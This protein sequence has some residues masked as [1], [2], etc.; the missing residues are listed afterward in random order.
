MYI[1]FLRLTVRVLF[2]S[3]SFNATVGDSSQT[4]E[5]EKINCTVMNESNRV[6]TLDVCY[7]HTRRKLACMCVCVCGSGTLV[8]E[9]VAAHSRITFYATYDIVSECAFTVY[10]TVYSECACYRVRFVWPNFY[11]Y[12]N[13]S[14][15]TVSTHF[16]HIR[17][18]Q[19]F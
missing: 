4:E 18:F 5:A 15:V 8:R 16:Q 6:L 9:C 7:G 1:V 14:A 10:S 13:S 11:F 12:R 3:V 2:D 17:G 19:S